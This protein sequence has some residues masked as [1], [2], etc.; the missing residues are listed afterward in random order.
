MLKR[1]RIQVGR[2]AGGHIFPLATLETVALA[3]D[4]DED[5]DAADTPMIIE[6]TFRRRRVSPQYQR[7]CGESDG[8]NSNMDRGEGSESAHA[9]AMHVISLIT[10]HT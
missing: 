7:V 1:E 9:I 3:E 6:K 5:D 10:Y 2:G 8:W 4:E